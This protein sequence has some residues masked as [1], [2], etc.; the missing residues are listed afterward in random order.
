MVAIQK[1]FS[2]M[3]LHLKLNNI[4]EKSKSVKKWTFSYYFRIAL[5]M[6]TWLC[7]KNLK[8]SNRN[9]ILSWFKK[10]KNE[11]KEELKSKKLSIILFHFPLGSC[12]VVVV[13]INKLNFHCKVENSG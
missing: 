11:E 4:M 6:A 12:K 13:Y 2:N 10:W 5:S 1:A 3:L 8:I 9:V 7:Q